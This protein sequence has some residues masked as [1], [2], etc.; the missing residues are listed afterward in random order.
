MPPT[1]SSPHPIYVSTQLANIPF[2]F[3]RKSLSEDDLPNPDYYLLPPSPSLSPSRSF[4]MSSS[5]PSSP[6]TLNTSPTRPHFDTARIHP[7]SS[8]THPTSYHAYGYSRGLSYS[9][10]SD[11]DPPPTE[12]KRNLPNSRSHHPIIHPPNPIRSTFSPFPTDRHSLQSSFSS[13]SQNTPV[14]GAYSMSL[15]FD[16]DPRFYLRFHLV[17]S[18]LSPSFLCCKTASEPV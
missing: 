4:S 6:T 8:P 5:P 7:P 1:R 15:G 13:V 9:G 2:R 12:F 14:H 18:L 16:P 17:T 11:H 3:R 10:P